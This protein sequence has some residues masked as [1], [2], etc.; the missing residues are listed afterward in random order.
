MHPFPFVAIIGTLFSPVAWAGLDVPSAK[1]L[2]D[3]D[4][5]CLRMNSINFSSTVNGQ[6]VEGSSG[7][8]IRFHIYTAHNLTLNIYTDPQSPTLRKGWAARFE[9]CCWR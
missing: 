4:V 7:D 5:L 8:Q 6:Q 1:R 3:F 2:P 9:Y